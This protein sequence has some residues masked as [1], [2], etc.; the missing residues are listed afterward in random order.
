MALIAFVIF[1]RLRSQ[2]RKD[3]T[4]KH[5][6]DELPEGGIIP[7][8]ANPDNSALVIPYNLDLQDVGGSN[9]N[10]TLVGEG[11]REKVQRLRY[12]ETVPRTS[13]SSQITSSSALPAASG[14]RVSTNA[15][16]PPRIS[17]LKQ[18]HDSG[19]RGLAPQASE[20]LPPIYTME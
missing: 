11:R 14:P 18:H 17:S 12:E 8:N 4:E 3:N 13:E 2:R 20:E 10:A 1:V 9:G 6:D 15:L 7:F 16:A 19:I 5:Y